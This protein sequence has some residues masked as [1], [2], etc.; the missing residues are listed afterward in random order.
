MAADSATCSHPWE[1]EPM[2]P[3][4]PLAAT[5]VLLLAFPAWGEPS[6]VGNIAS[7]QAATV[8]GTSVTPGSTIF[9]GDI[10]EVGARGS[11]R[12]ALVGEAQLQVAQNSQVRLTKTSEVIQVAVERGGISFRAAE[13]SP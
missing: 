12:L 1:T 3:R 11:A 5:L 2:V 13:K 6:V 10:I 8:R 4:K 9:S 7:S